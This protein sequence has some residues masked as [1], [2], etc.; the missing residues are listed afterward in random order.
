MAIVPALIVSCEE[1]AFA[2]PQVSLIE[3]VRLD[4]ERFDT[5]LEN[6]KGATFYRLRGNLLPLVYLSE[7]LRINM[8]RPQNRERKK[9]KARV[10]NI[11]VVR[12][13][14]QVFGL[15]V[16]DVHD[17]EEIVVKS[18]SKSIKGLGVYAGAT[19]MGDGRVALIL[20]VMNLAQRSQVIHER[21]ASQEE[22]NT[23]VSAV[24]TQE[25]IPLL[26]VELGNN[27]PAAIPLDSVK[28]LEEFSSS[29]VEFLNGRSVV[30]YRGGILDLVDL[31]TVN[32]YGGQGAGPDGDDACQVIV[33]ND[34]TR[35]VGFMVRGIMDVVKHSIDT[36]RPAARHG[37]KGAAII[38]EKIMDVLDLSMLA[39]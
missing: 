32:G 29:K 2:I 27:E 10:I 18:L 16:D 22:E 17:T 38:Q 35:Q 5:D 26:I 36:T 23:S 28:R 19:I 3:L 9:G 30:Q 12:A 6:I 25:E 14:T 1:D 7:E 13:D 24:S 15:V 34:N 31:R 21:V 8:V 4:E 37:S 39:L 20:D 33:L 11:V